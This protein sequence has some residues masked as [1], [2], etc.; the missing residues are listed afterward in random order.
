MPYTLHERSQQN[1]PE[2]NKCTE[3]MLQELLPE[4]FGKTEE[5]TSNQ[6]KLKRPSKKQR[7]RL[8]RK[9]QTEASS[10]TTTQPEKNP[11]LL[12]QPPEEQELSISTYCSEEKDKTTT[13]SKSGQ[14][15]PVRT[16]DFGSEVEFGRFMTSIM[17]SEHQERIHPQE[18]LWC[19][20]EH[21]NNMPPENKTT[22][23]E[24]ATTS[25]PRNQQKAP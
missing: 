20:N 5:G 6:Q 17:P 3:M 2:R 25:L 23:L 10:E 15:S 14:N 21:A 9:E 19:Q 13:P 8:R 22:Q 12:Q 1:N 24:A 11:D 7:E 16:T 18:G 4:D